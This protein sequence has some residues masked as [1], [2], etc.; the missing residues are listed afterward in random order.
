MYILSMAKSKYEL[1]DL[2][3]EV[4][5]I[6]GATSGIGKAAAYAL[7]EAGCK[8][9]LNARTEAKLKDL[10]NDLGSENAIYVAGDCSSPE[11][12][13]KLV[14]AALAKFGKFPDKC[15]IS[16]DRS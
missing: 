2:T 12:N 8:V 13:R 7:V 14:A 15:I 1:R 6:T 10:V 16:I 4:V 9:V 11:L 5:I 3:G